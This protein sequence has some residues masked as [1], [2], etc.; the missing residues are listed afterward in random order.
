VAA[1]ITDAYAISIVLEPE[2][3]DLGDGLVFQMT[4][5]HYEEQGYPKSGLYRDGE[6]I[7]TH[8]I[9][10][11][12][13]QS[14]FFSDDAMSVLV[15]PISYRGNIRF[16]QQGVLMHERRV[17][18]L[19]RHGF[20]HI[21]YCEFGLGGIWQIHRRTYHDRANNRLRITTVENYEITFDLTTGYILSQYKISVQ[22]A[23]PTNNNFMFIVL[24]LIG[25]FALYKVVK[26]KKRIKKS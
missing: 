10:D 7:Y 20:P 25:I 26:N 3:I 22:T 17:A 11:T 21:E 1:C 14:L 2:K 4:P 19:S 23:P 24:C 16:Y 9:S 12:F 18:N 6:L 8:N 5:P 15:V 13:F